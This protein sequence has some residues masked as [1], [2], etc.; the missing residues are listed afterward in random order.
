MSTVDLS[1]MVDLP[2]VKALRKHCVDYV[3][4]AVKGKR[5]ACLLSGGVDSNMCLFAALEAGLTPTV[6]TFMLDGIES[7]DFRTARRT[8]DALGL[9]FVPVI[10]S[11][12]IEELR[13]H[14]WNVYHKFLPEFKVGKSTVE[15]TWPI[16]RTLDVINEPYWLLG[17]GGDPPYCSMR[18]QKKAYL[19]GDYEKMLTTYYSYLHNDLQLQYHDKYLASIK[20]KSQRVAPLNDKAMLKIF[21]GFDPFNKTHC[22]TQKAVSRAAFWDYFSH[23]RIYGQQGFQKGDTGIADHFEGLMDTDWQLTGKTVVSIY[24]RVQYSEVPPPPR[25][26]ASNLRSNLRTKKL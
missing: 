3:R 1:H 23:I 20:K 13:E 8:A 9:E 18:K 10:L 7:R 12:D 5:V 21:K 6:Y 25:V 26:A 2:R 19:A 14:V 17:F 15:C 24:N 22:P 4:S 16:A 11:T